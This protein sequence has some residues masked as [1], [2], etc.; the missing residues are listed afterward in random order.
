MTDLKVGETAKTLN[1]TTTTVRNWVNAF[2]E[3]LS[4]SAQLQRRKRFTPQDITILKEIQS[5]SNDG[6][7][8][9]EIPDRLNDV[10]L[11]EVLDFEE[12]PPE[13]IPDQQ[14]PPQ[15][16]ALAIPEVFEFITQALDNAAAQHERE[17]LAKDET[18]QLLRD[19]LNRQRQPWWKRL[20]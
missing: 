13:E 15:D 10:P 5:L 16:N 2:G 18:I 17:I 1:T 7:T 9:A 14:P 8:Y 4:P 3:F 12:I 6:F 11:Q 20:F 19:E